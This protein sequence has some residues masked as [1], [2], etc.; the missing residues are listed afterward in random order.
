M[1][2]QP[3]VQP[4]RVKPVAAEM[5]KDDKYGTAAAIMAL[6]PAKLV[7]LLKDANSSVYAKAKA[8]QRLAVI[9]DKSAVPALAALL[10]DPQLSHYARV[11]LE[12]I[13][14][15]SA[16]EALRSALGKV[17]GRLLAGVITS[18]G[19]RRDRD[20]IAALEKLR[21]DTDSDV[22]RA[23]DAALARIRPPL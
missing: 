21:H 20:A 19:S 2:Q 14:D 23:A 8:C 18:I 16:D 1:A 17:Q 6:P 22:A 9:G 12:P 3:T 7:A 15:R 5:M 11:A 10:A 13:P 4:S